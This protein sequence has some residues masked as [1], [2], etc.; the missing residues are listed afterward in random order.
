MA[1]RIA[2][3]NAAPPAAAAAVA[4]P[5][6]ANASRAAALLVRS[7]SASLS[8]RRALWA[9]VLL[10]SG[11]TLYV[12]ASLLLPIMVACT[13]ALLLSPAVSALNRMRLPAPLSAGLVMLAVLLALG[14]LALNVAGPVQRWIE[15][16][17]E[18]LRKLEGRLSTFMGPVE[19][20]RQATEKVSEIAASESKPKPREVVLERR[21]ASS[22]I[23]VTVDTLVMVLSTAMLV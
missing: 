10:A 14:T 1:A 17:P 7:S 3:Q 18:Q 16:A 5:A 21:G 8:M 9:L 15:T 22:V 12:T 13:V 19:A 6:Q 23:N 11:Y 2:P 20:V 4:S